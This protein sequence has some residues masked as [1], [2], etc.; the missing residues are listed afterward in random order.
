MSHPVDARLLIVG[1]GPGDPSL[2]T[3]GAQRALD[4]AARI[5]LR[6]RIH[7]GLEDLAEDPRVGDCDDLYDGSRS[8]EEVYA[9]IA[10]RLLRL[11]AD[12]DGGQ[13]VFAVPGHPRFGERSVCLIEERAA[14][15]GIAL[16]VMAA[17]STVDAVAAALAI[18][19]MSD[20][21]QLVDA[22][23]LAAAVERDPFAGGSIAVDPHRPCLVGQVYAPRVAAAVKLALGRLYPDDHPIVLVRAAGVPGDERL[24]RCRLFELDR[25]PVDHLTS[26]WVPAME[27][28][29][30]FR[31]PAELQ[32]IVALLRAPGGCPWDRDQSHRSL[33]PAVIEE[34]YEVVD[35]I[36][37]DDADNLEE[38]LGDLLLQVV[39]HAQIAEEAGTFTLEDVCERVGRK[40]IRRHPHVFGDAE[41]RTA[42]DVVTTWEAVKAEERA[43]QGVDTA[44]HPLDRLPRSMPALLRAASLLGSWKQGPPRTP[45]PVAIEAAG[46]ALLAA[47]ASAVHAGVDPE[48]ALDAALRRR[49]SVETRQETP[50]ANGPVRTGGNP[51]S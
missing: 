22:L 7:P 30:A 45:D 32:R 44:A 6:T 47:V 2:R 27:A 10:D 3:A 26:V 14:G 36:D 38:E 12:R 29:T 21:A 49:A 24:T 48:R 42:G 18:D 11:A 50:A 37:R 35:A 25:R 16:A 46:E 1:L 8:F 17:V 5:V 28:L 51:R 31:S 41:A 13:V 19:P 33:R 4:G 9:A 20:E 39:L 43:G 23:A 34:A 40:L 15:R